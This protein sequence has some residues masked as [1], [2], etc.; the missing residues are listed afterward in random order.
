MAKDILNILQISDTHIF[1]NKTGSLLGVQTYDSLEAVLAMIQTKHDKVDFLLHSGDVSQDYSEASY[2]LAESM[3]EKLKLP[4]YCVPGNH[5]DPKVMARVYPRGCC[6]NQK[7]IL[8]RHWQVILL[9]SHKPGEVRGYLDQKELDF[10]EHCLN[11]HPLHHAL[12][13]FHH[14]PF[15]VGCAWLDKLGL[16]N[17]DHF[18]EVISRYPQVNTVLFGHVHQEVSQQYHDINCYSAPSTCIQFK[19]KQDHFGLENLPQGYRWLKLHED[20]RVETAVERLPQYIGSFE[21]HAKGY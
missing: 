6:H 21:R 5:D 11:A 12:V 3:F 9:D 7:S 20:G 16:T 17:A 14:H 13:V 18:W 2:V 10:M 15:P 1:G 19:R 8:T 4:V